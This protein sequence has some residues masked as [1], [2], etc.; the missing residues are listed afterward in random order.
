M[1]G[2]ASQDYL[3]RGIT[4]DIIV[5]LTAFR[6]LFVFA[7]KTSMAID[8]DSDDPL[9][10][11]ERLGARYVV[12][13]SVQKADSRIRISARLASAG[14]GRQLWANRFDR[15][16]Q[17]LFAV[18]DEVVDMIANS[19]VEN[20]EAAHH[21]QAASE[22]P[23]NLGAYDFILRGR[24]LLN[25]YTH[26][27]EL[28]ARRNFQ[29]AIDLDPNSAAAHAGLAVS[30]IHE[31]EAPWCEHPEQ[32]LSFVFES[33]RKALELDSLNI[34]ALYALGGAYYYNGEYEIANLEIEKA[35]AINPHDYHN[36]CS[37]A[38]FMTF[39][40]HLQ[41][42]LAC[43]IDAMRLNPYAADGCLETIGIG[44][45]LSGDYE[46]AL[47]AYGS[48]KGNSLFK[49]G[50]LSASYAQLDRVR[51]ATRAAKEFMMVADLAD[52]FGDISTN[53][54]WRS[55][56]DRMFQ[57]KHPSDREHYFDGLRKA[58]IPVDSDVR[59]S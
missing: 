34:M 38:W 46:Q 58:G 19:L 52:S 16:L 32:T 2:D 7:Y 47:E 13:G 17:D 43:S 26:E 57:F 6:E 15:D 20:V 18:Q 27:A 59:P 56:W 23:E 31:Y 24:L 30:H 8:V 41:E 54:F 22:S 50:G 14:D 1:S 28:E 40:G 55:Y 49:L 29:S 48:T 39:S 44:R 10:V 45:Y 42:G 5:S 9:S 11:A 37:K 53:R 35:I 36:L 25:R 51:E 4:D 12:E 21:R 3:A 33:A